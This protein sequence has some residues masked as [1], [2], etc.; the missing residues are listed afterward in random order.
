MDVQTKL[1]LQEGSAVRSNKVMYFCLVEEV[2]EACINGLANEPAI[3]AEYIMTVE[4]KKSFS[5]LRSS[6][7]LTSFFY[8]KQLPWERK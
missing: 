7:M 3:I 8:R 1:L 6:S 5:L 4:E 2:E